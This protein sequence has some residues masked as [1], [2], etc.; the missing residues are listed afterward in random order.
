T[1][2]SGSGTGRGRSRTAFTTEKMAVLTPMPRVSAATAARANAGLWTKTRRA[3]FTSRSRVS[4]IRLPPREFGRPALLRRADPDPAVLH[5]A[6]IAF[7]A[8]GAGGGNL[9]PGRVEQLAVAGAGGDP[10]LHRH[11]ELVPFLRP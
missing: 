9:D 4:G 11:H 1:S 6:A 5:L 2:R 8:D 10:V 7:E 3:C